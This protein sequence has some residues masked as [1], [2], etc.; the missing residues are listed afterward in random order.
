[1]VICLGLSAA[2]HQHMARNK[3]GMAIPG[4][5]CNAQAVS[6][7]PNRKSFTAKGGA[8]DRR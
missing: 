3:N 4:L 5:G 1:V 6:E 2:F 7:V 8:T